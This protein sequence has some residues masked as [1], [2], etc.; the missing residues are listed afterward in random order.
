[1]EHMLLKDTDLNAKL[2]VMIE[3][4]KLNQFYVQYENRTRSNTYGNC[5]I[6]RNLNQVKASIEILNGL[7][8]TNI[9]EVTIKFHHRH[10]E[11]KRIEKYDFKLAVMKKFV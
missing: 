5:F 9:S 11:A 7:I 4:R 10:N 2:G 8:F 3:V 1:M 6:N